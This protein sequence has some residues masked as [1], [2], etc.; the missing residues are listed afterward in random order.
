[1]PAALGEAAFRNNTMDQR[2]KDKLAHTA[3]APGVYRMYDEHDQIIYIGKA[4]DLKKRLTSY[5][6]GSGSMDVK[7]RVLVKK[8]NRFDTIL[9]RNE[10]EALILESNLIKRHRPRYNVELKDDKRYPSLR[11]DMTEEYPSLSIVRKTK[12]D[13]AL[14]FG[15]YAS[16]GA[17]RQTLKLI[18]KTFKIRKCRHGKFQKRSRP[19]LHCQMGG[20]L[21]PCCNPVAP[22]RYREAV[23][24]VIL[25]LKGR[26]PQL[27]AS[28]RTEM[29]AAAADKEFEK[30]A[31]LRD[32]MQAL[33]RTLERQVAV[34]TDF[35]D[36]DILAVAHSEEMRLITLL[37]VRGG[38]LQG[39]RHFEIPAT[40]AET[41]EMLS[42]FIRQYYARAS[43]LPNEILVC[44]PLPDADA[45]SDWLRQTEGTRVK[46][47]FPQRGEKAK[48]IKLARENA[49]QALEER[50]KAAQ[51]EQI[52]LRRLQSRLKLKRLP[53]R[54]ECLDNSNLSGMEPVASLVVFR[55]A[56]P[57]KSD[58][59]KFR[60]RSVTEPDDYA[61]MA[62]VLTR[63][64]GKNSKK[65]P[66]MP[67]LLV[68]DGGRGQVGIALRVLQSL[69]LDKAFD[70]IGIAKA[71]PDRGDTHDKVYRPGR[72]N[73][74]AFGREPDLR[75]F[76]QRIRDEAHRT[77]V[78]FHRQRRSKRGLDSVMDAI[79]QIGPRRKATLLKHFGSVKHIARASEAE[80]TALPGM[81]RKAAAAV[82]HYL[83]GKLN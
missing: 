78:A 24:E 29:L 74:I 23:D 36:R 53:V 7:T 80:L 31:A 12:S 65:M 13:G 62:E 18:Q 50:L 41:G 58:Y 46:L 38:F 60:I 54:I 57:L 26:T 63:R 15:P 61:Y 17:V 76:L 20:C 2:L 70:I 59:R 43:F 30:A 39:G 81:N 66:T 35:K 77:A 32:K 73:P 83:R 10:K 42:A 1:V 67:D 4:Q 27:I 28:I 51:D 45:I 55:N 79:P 22:E 82:K 25:F 21:G 14:Y 34:T 64:F 69:N 75:L 16:A 33:E 52:L 6:S 3:R 9:T 68:L 8:I 71:N 19:C 37:T 72:A 5:F 47:K 48:L 11:L 49:T 56:Q 40:L 44:T